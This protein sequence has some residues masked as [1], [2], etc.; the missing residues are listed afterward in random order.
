[1][2]TRFRAR[3]VLSN[4]KG[5]INF[6]RCSVE[7]QNICRRALSLYKVYG[8]SALLILN[9]TYLISDSALLAVV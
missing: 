7:N 3:R 9:G 2:K 1:M 4:F 8:D 5:A 6:Q